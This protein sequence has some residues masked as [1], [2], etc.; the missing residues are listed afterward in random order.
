MPVLTYVIAA[1]LI[2]S[3][4]NR[5]RSFKN[6]A[7]YA[8]AHETCLSAAATVIDSNLQ[9][10]RLLPG[11]RFWVSTRRAWYYS[12]TIDVFT[13]C[14]QFLHLHTFSATM[15]LLL[16]L[17][18]SIDSDAPNAKLI[19][20]ERL[21]QAESAIEIFQHTKRTSRVPTCQRMGRIGEASKR[22]TTLSMD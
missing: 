14:L 4:A 18:H 21:R 6:P 1:V 10:I 15:C 7:N 12:I 17:M 8:Y 3:L 13:P 19:T 5:F 22:L 11:E 20:E 2:E 16:D 9:A